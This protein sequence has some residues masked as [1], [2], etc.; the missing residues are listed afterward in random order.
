MVIKEPTKGRS[1]LK[2]RVQKMLKD[3]LGVIDTTLEDAGKLGELFG[4]FYASNSP[5]T[6]GEI[7]TR[8]KALE[9]KYYG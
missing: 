1:D 5:L 8:I 9:D 3:Q 7:E 4:W 2:G 6:E